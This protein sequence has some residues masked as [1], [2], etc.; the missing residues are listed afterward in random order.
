MLM[1]FKISNHGSR[2]GAVVAPFEC[3]TQGE[4]NTPKE[5]DK[6]SI[7]KNSKIL[8]LGFYSVVVSTLDFESSNASSN[9]ARSVVPIFFV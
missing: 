5:L 7:S 2:R 1:L 9:L 4:E 6:V 8:L 3:C